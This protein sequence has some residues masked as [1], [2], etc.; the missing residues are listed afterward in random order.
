[1]YK[2]TITKTD[3][4]KEAYNFASIMEYKNHIALTKLYSNYEG[5][6]QYKN[7]RFEIEYIRQ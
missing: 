6:T 4:T 1:M 3:G 5:F 7:A 2:L